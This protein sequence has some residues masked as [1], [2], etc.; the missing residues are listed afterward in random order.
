M[1]TVKEV[2][3]LNDG[4]KISACKHK[5][6]DTRLLHTIDCADFS[7]AASRQA[8]ADARLPLQY[9]DS[10]AHLLIPL[11]KCRHN[12]Y[13]LPWKCEVRCR[14]LNPWSSSKETNTPRCC[15]TS[16]IVTRNVSTKSSRR[17]L[18]RWM[19]SEL[20]RA[21]RGATRSWGAFKKRVAKM[22][23]IRAGEE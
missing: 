5:L 9:R 15:R 22:D 13:Y 17:E 8:M 19:K 21:G 20:R 23:E 10:C 6:K 18:R 16:D 3:G 14:M 1:E 4:G 2:V 12:E 11:N 7:A